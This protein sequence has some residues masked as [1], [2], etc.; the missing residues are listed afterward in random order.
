M[1]ELSPESSSTQLHSKPKLYLYSQQKRLTPELERWLSAFDWQLVSTLNEL[2]HAL[3][4]D[5]TNFI[6]LDVRH[7]PQSILEQI[8]FLHENF[9]RHLLVTVIDEQYLSLGQESLEMGA[10]LYVCQ[11][12]CTAQ[13]LSMQLQCAAHQKERNSVRF[14]N[15]YLQA[16]AIG[17]ALFLD[18]L[19]HAL[20]VA[21]RH[22]CHTGV[23]LVGLD[24]YKKLSQKMS[25]ADE[26]ALLQ[27]A[28]QAIVGAIRNSDSLGYLGLGVFSV[29]LEDLQDEVMVA[30]IAKKIQHLFT[31]PLLINNTRIDISV[32]IGGHLCLGDE[33]GAQAMQ[34]QAGMALK[35]AQKNGKESMYF[36]QQSLNFKTMARAN[37]E[38][39]LIAALKEQQLFLQYQ[40]MHSGKG[41]QII[42]MESQIRWQHPT[43]GVV[44]PDIFI[45]LVEDSGLIIEVGNWWIQQSLWQFKHWQ[46]SGCI[47]AR[48]QIFISIS[49]K[50][51]RCESFI[52][53]LVRQLA[54][55]KLASEKVVLMINEK[56]A[57]RNV[58]QLQTLSKYVPGICLAVCL[59][60]FANGYSSLSYLREIDVDYL[61]LDESFFQHIYTDQSKMSV[62]RII[63]DI[64][65]NLGIEVMARGAHSQLKVD[66]MQSLEI[67]IL[68]G[69]FF[70]APIYGDLWPEYI[71]K[72]IG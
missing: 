17:Q 53:M 12:H 52:N 46:V 67:D 27:T 36:Y 32:S 61:C 6:L 50:Q 7:A 65:H 30:H 11:G 48:Q 70:C 31:S 68:Q 72:S 34:L 20:M 49:E 60:D 54:L 45:G 35:R 3:L 55:N 71:R 59:C 5:G 64:A 40:P 41:H 39:G 38:E 33:I 10:D 14:N 4:D 43:S 21:A 62:A 37:M 2:R 1:L 16:G 44:L 58:E 13:G 47:E 63:I 24:D 18:R 66:K 8:R 9:P 28:S 22:Q 56:T 42:A 69:E 57:V 26:K 29:L 15:D 19:T 25:L 51:L 23:L